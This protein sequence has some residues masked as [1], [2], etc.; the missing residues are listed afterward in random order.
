MDP[1]ARIILF[2]SHARGD[3]D[4]ES[5][6]DF[7]ILTGKKESSGIEKEFR[8]PLYEIEWDTGNVISAIVFNTKEWHKH[9]LTSF[10]Q[11]VLKDG[12]EL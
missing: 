5:D 12:I 7:L 9:E 1:R 2:G 10:Y 8:Y 4:A 11:N 3:A 6:W